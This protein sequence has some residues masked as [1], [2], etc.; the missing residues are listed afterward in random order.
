MCIKTNPIVII[1]KTALM[2]LFL[3]S[4]FGVSLLLTE[5]VLAEQDVQEEQQVLDILQIKKHADYSDKGADTCLKCH[6]EDSEF[7]VL[8]IFMTPHA[9]K[10]DKRTPFAK[11]QCETCHGPVGEHDKSRLRKG[12]AREPMIAFNPSSQIPVIERNKICSGCHQKIEK[13]HWQGSIHEVSNV[14]CSDCH[15]V[16][17]TEDPIQSNIAQVE[18]CGSC[19]QSHKLASTRYSTHP[20]KYGQMGCTGCHNLHE[21]DNEHLLNGETVNDTCFDCHAEKRGPFL[22]EH[23]P[24]T[25]DCG[26]CHEAHGS[27]QSA[28]LTQRSPFLCQ[29]CHSS[30]GH[31]STANDDSGL[32]E[33]RFP[34]L[35]TGSTLLLGRACANCHSKV[36][37]SNH[38][39]GSKLQR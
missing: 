2:A 21:T 18:K 37:G 38:P 1:R 36:H 24:A 11:Q 30:Q 4:Y 3:T 17:A 14:A 29:N 19:H 32:I 22:W 31:P 28:M 16:H 8:D 27:N 13:S 35:R 23:E 15:K 26:L 33:R 25:E 34:A 12:E 20:L 39:S 10:S 7:P 5:T 9:T 6:D